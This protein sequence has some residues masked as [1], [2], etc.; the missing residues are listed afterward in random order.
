MV[1]WQAGS[2]AAQAG[3]I[4]AADESTGAVIEGG[5]SGQSAPSDRSPGD[6]SPAD[7]LAQENESPSLLYGTANSGSGA[8]SPSPTFGPSAGLVALVSDG[9]STAPNTLTSRLSLHSRISLP[10]PLEDRFF[11][12]PRV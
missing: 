8:G 12:P 11:R 9:P 5:M 2:S 3:L 10:S 6:R 4:V 7:P 1:T